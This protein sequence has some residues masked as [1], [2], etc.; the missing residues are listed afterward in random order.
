MGASYRVKRI[1]R[2]DQTRQLA[3]SADAPRELFLSR[4]SFCA[5]FSP[6]R[7]GGAT[8]FPRAIEHMPSEMR[9]ETDC[10]HAHFDAQATTSSGAAWSSAKPTTRARTKTRWADL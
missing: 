7:F 3:G 1:G 9:M 6:I 4:R 2:A 5:G 8:A 10:L